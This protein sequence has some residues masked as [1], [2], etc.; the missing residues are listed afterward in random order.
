[1]LIVIDQEMNG[2]TGVGKAFVHVGQE[3]NDLLEILEGKSF[4][5]IVELR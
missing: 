2:D 3:A 4:L 1:M 5:F